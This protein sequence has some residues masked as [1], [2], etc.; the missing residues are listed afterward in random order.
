MADRITLNF[1]AN[2]GG[3]E[4]GT[5]RIVDG[6]ADVEDAT[7]DVGRASRETE[8][9]T[10]GL[11]DVGD[12]AD[13]AGKSVESAGDKAADSL[14]DVNDKADDV[15]SGLQKLGGA[16]KA[17]IDG[18]AAGAVQG[19]ADGLSGLAENLPLVGGAVAVG[20]GLIGTALGEASAAA[21]ET[22]SNI[23]SMYEA[24]AADGRTFLDEAQIQ[25]ESL[26]I[27]YGDDQSRYEQA[28]KD[29]RALGLPWQ[30]VVRAIAGDQE[31]LNTVLDRTNELEEA[32]NQKIEESKGPLELR[33]N[34]MTS[35]GQQLNEINDRYSTQ[36]GY[37]DE[38]AA[39]TAQWLAT[40]QLSTEEIQKANKA[41]AE[42]PKS[43]A[44]VLAPDTSAI[45][46]AL[47]TRTLR[48]DVAGYNN[49]G[50]RVI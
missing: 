5:D 28:I 3:L 41:L 35:E 48:I 9:L 46:R 45:D 1:D 27:L 23:R 19:L 33:G 7:K 24:A 26:K 21:E 10:D 17:A 29:S 22:R 18:D 20:I 34:L 13:D 4:K 2:T 42:T 43:I 16:A 8:K 12:A 31:A 44:V 40:Q 6:L 25:A 47:Y 11:D 38:N 39:R 32:R 36:K 37:I 30:E 50:Q 15:G 14:S 49:Y